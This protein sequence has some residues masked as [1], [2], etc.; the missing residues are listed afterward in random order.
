[1]LRVHH[2]RVGLLSIGEEDLKGNSLTRDTLPLL[3]AL[4]DIQ[5]IGN[6]EGRDLFNGHSDVAVC[7]GFVGNVALKAIEGTAQLLSASLRH[8]LK[9]TVTSQVG[10]LLS[11]KA[12]NEFKKRLDYSEYGG[13]VLLG[14]R[15]ACIIGHGSSNERAIMN[16]VRVTAE[17]AQAEVNSGIEAALRPVPAIPLP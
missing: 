15:G 13:A 6:V 5:F 12:F 16:G 4:N 17:Y 10:A 2:P 8:S 3:R 11:R 9:S 7:D 14:V 1:V